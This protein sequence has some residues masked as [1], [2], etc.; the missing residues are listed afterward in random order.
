MFGLKQDSEVRSRHKDR[1]EEVNDGGSSES[2]TLHLTNPV[3]VSPWNF[4]GNDQNSR[5]NM[6][7]NSTECLSFYR[8]PNVKTDFR[9][10]N[11][12]LKH[13]AKYVESSANSQSLMYVDKMFPRNYT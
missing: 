10:G 4:V 12:A 2:K 7:E 6:R 3:H 1:S 5:L 8:F 13:D 11:A 9:K